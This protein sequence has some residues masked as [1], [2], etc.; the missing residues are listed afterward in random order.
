MQFGA[1]RSVLRRGIEATDHHEAFKRLEEVV[2][3]LLV[4]LAKVAGERGLAAN[5]TDLIGRKRYE[6]LLAD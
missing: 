4:L 6:R 5:V 3:R 1:I 2:Q